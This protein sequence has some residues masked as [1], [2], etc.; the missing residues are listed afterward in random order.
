MALHRT[1]SCLMLLACCSLQAQTQS[2]AYGVSICEKGLRAVVSKSKSER[3]VLAH[4][5]A[6]AHPKL[7]ARRDV[8]LY[9][10]YAPDDAQITITVNPV[11]LRKHVQVISAGSYSGYP[12]RRLVVDLLHDVSNGNGAVTDSLMISVSWDR[13]LVSAAPLLPPSA[14]VFLNASWLPRL[15]KYV[16]KRENTHVLVEPQSWYDRFA[17]Y[18]KVHTSRDGIAMIRADDVLVDGNV[19]PLDGIALY[20]RGI[21]Q[22][23][24]I[25]DVDS[26]GTLSA[27]DRI[28]FR[29]R[30]PEGDSTY[31][32][33]QDST[34]MFY[35]TTAKQGP[36]K[37][38]GDFLFASSAND[39]LTSVYVRQ[40]IE[41][42]TGYY[43]PGSGVDEDQSIFESSLVYLEGFYWKNLYGRSKQH[44]TFTT[45]FTPAQAGTTRV[46]VV[47]ATTT[48]NSKYAPEHVVSVWPPALQT[49]I[50]QET[51]GFQ[52]VTQSWSGASASMPSGLQRVTVQAT[53]TDELRAQ[54]DWYS[55]VLVDAIEI[56]GDA[57][58][59]LDSGRLHC[60]VAVAQ[61]ALLQLHNVKAGRVYVLDTAKLTFGAINDHSA[62]RTVRA[63]I[64]PDVVPDVAWDGKSFS[65]SV[66]IGS[67]TV[68][69]D[70]L[71]ALYALVVHDTLSDVLETYRDLTSAQ[72]RVKLR[73]ISADQLVVVVNAGSAPDRDL[74]DDLQMRG[75]NVQ[76]SEVQDVWIAAASNGMGSCSKQ[77]G[78]TAHF[79]DARGSDGSARLLLTKGSHQVY[80]S[81][82]SGIEQARVYDAKNQGVFADTAF[83]DVIA[84][85]HKDH[86]QEASRWAQHRFLYSGKRV[87]L[88]DVDAIIEE[89]GA[90]RH[91][92]EAIRAFLIDAFSKSS[93]KPSHCVLIGN[94]SWDARL[95]IKEGN[96]GAKRIDQ[97][98]TYGRPSTDM[99][100]GL[101]DDE[102]DLATPELLVSRFPVSTV[103]ECKNVIDKIIT[104][105][106][107]LYSPEMRR[108]LFVGGGTE[109]ENFCELYKRMLDD[110]FGS[111]IVFT[112][113]PLCID[114]VTVC[115][116]DY[117]KPG[118]E[119]R[120]KINSGA[121]WMNY[122]G[123]GGT[124]VF[125]IADWDP[126]D[127]NNL[128]RY[129]IL[130]TFSCLTGNY[131]SPNALCE[132]A[133]Y[134]VEKNKG[135][136]AAMGATGY[137]Y[138][139]VVDLL[140]FR[141]H[142]AMLTK[143]LRTISDLT[144]EA[145]RAFSTMNN[146]VGR[147]AALQYCILGDPF[148]RLRIDT[149]PD[150]RVYAANVRIR[151]EVGGNAVYLQQDVFTVDVKI[152]NA[153]VATREP[154]EVVVRRFLPNQIQAADSAV[155]VVNEGL[156][157]ASLV[158]AT[159]STAIVGKHRIEV[160][161]DPRKYTGYSLAYVEASVSVDVL[162]RSLKIVVPDEY[163]NISVSRPHFRLLY[164]YL[165]VD[166]ATERLMLTLH[167]SREH[168][169][170]GTAMSLSGMQ[171][172]DHGSYVDVYYSPSPA[173]VSS[174][175]TARHYWMRASSATSD[176]VV[177]PFLFRKDI[178][179]P[180]LHVV[181]AVGGFA[182][183]DSIH[184][185]ST[186][187]AVSLAQ[188]FVPI[189]LQSR[190]K[191]SSDPVRLP[192]L[193][194]AFG[195]TTIQSSFRNGINI[196]VIRPFSTKPR[197]IRRYDT[198]PTPSPRETGHYGGP[199]ECI[200]FLRDSIIENEIVAIAACNESFTQFEN[201]GYMS[202]FRQH[203][204]S[205]GCV[206][207][208]SITIGSSLVFVGS[209]DRRRRS[210]QRI[211]GSQSNDAASIDDSLEIRYS[212]AALGQIHVERP[213]HLKFIQLDSSDEALVVI[214]TSGYDTAEPLTDTTSSLWTAYRNA[215]TIRSV[216]IMP[217]L[218][219]TDQTPDPVF[220]SMTISY[221]PAPML[222]V[223]SLSISVE[224]E[225]SLRGDSVRTSYTVRNLHT[226]YESPSAWLT[227]LAASNGDTSLKQTTQ[228]ILPSIA[229]D[230]TVVL[231][232]RFYND[233][234]WTVIRHGC[235]IDVPGVGRTLH[236]V[237]QSASRVFAPREDSTQPRAAVVVNGQQV[238]TGSTVDSLP[239]IVVQLRDASKL[240]ITTDD[241][242]VV[243]VNGL[244]IRASNARGY[245]FL[246]STQ[247]ADEF[248]ESDVRAAVEFR[249]PM[250][251]GENLVI[252]RVTDASGNKDT[253]EV[254]LRYSPVAS[255]R[256]TSLGPNPATDGV[257]FQT[258]VSGSAALQNATF[259]VSD[260]Q[261]RQVY[262]SRVELYTG[263][264]SY[265]W[266]GMS[267]NGDSLVPGV[268][269][270]SLQIGD[271]D[272][273][274][275]ENRSSGMVIILR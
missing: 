40:H 74:V 54:T 24:F 104:S 157:S 62:G 213:Q 2:T 136:V 68:V 240:P 203:L 163:G 6:G 168:A 222:Y 212:R 56:S 188:R 146:Q 142:E 225:A 209:K 158:S 249:F 181:C 100:F 130:A 178:S 137:Q 198:S 38:F 115:N 131:S 149:V 70:S 150:L 108:F 42:D 80:L 36:R 167:T 275:V 171:L 226:R 52:S 162:N 140:H 120:Q 88:Y 174:I 224:P 132:N 261:G 73:Q 84:I 200:A 117:A 145:K 210:I 239:L 114:T 250:E 110:S 179:D 11:A 55:E 138:L 183:N 37:R 61:N 5:A 232:E 126:Q 127:L 29:G 46:D 229:A 33:V 106:T 60:S 211:V 4:R 139:P 31:Y 13:P 35:I 144:Y 220:R 59:V 10:F 205:I 78:L 161:I 48:A 47:Y 260:L 160:V 242:F 87:S 202:Q 189:A 256:V 41:Q 49:P 153:G 3:Y 50:R 112:E 236:P 141:F 243:F 90:G 125:D 170:Q 267:S 215:S 12:I 27:S 187:L 95:A 63:G 57:A 172:V 107:A 28:F 25:D 196:V 241:N 121:G 264:S 258:T 134:L 247:C 155:V 96:V 76:D 221:Q 94:A 184:V 92:P 77:Q 93:K 175:D 252:A 9:E 101:L 194:M 147:N 208:D 67:S 109:Q 83:G 75:A 14:G 230:E 44:A 19:A 237:F 34:A 86:L 199:A 245:R 20:W 102:Y 244:R 154:V 99:W 263:S 197:L 177:R 91:G 223:D 156:C 227:V 257:T 135:M 274:P 89:Y 129:P 98:P 128:G 53:G 207:T 185:D 173:E 176:A 82:I 195:D 270:W 133:S 234:T 122:I 182:E 272:Q 246:N 79:P 218:I 32:D 72:L 8:L 39:T 123:H 58:P 64:W 259:V 165:R 166:T 201:Q 152:I 219:A 151:D 18:K 81:D 192:S 26:T 217:L 271:Q 45:R 111:D 204:E 191:P 180:D 235:S 65:A 17:S 214:N 216:Q 269:C 15:T 21:E 105:D 118:L 113:P 268:Y 193:K 71:K 238:V 7:E 66:T 206:G 97:V 262:R 16:K 51:N 124:D 143:G 273:V 233:P 23:V 22:S 85:A 164:P 1:I 253:T 119:I 254:F 116:T 251:Q 169:L 266:D 190:G 30:R 148:T 69:L 186:M 265:T 255:V 228:R 43:H 103:D 159:F 248:P 231:Q